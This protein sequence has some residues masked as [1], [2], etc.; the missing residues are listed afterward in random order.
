VYFA[1]FEPMRI[2][3]LLGTAAFMVVGTLVGA[4]VLSLALRTRKLPELYVGGSLFLFAAVGQPLVV[5]SRPLGAAFGYGV[6]AAAVTLAVTA[7][8]AS[9]AGMV[10]FTRTVFRADSSAARWGVWGLASLA[11]LSGLAVVC[12][13][14]E[15]PGELNRSMRLGIAGI[16]IAFCL[17]KA[18]TAWESLRYHRLLRR[19]LALGLSDRVVVNRFLLWGSG[20]GTAC[21]SALAMIA[22]VAAGLDIAVH[23]VPLLTTAASGTLI[24]IC[25]YLT[26]LPPVGYLRWITGDAAGPLGA[27]GQAR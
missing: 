18:W 25:W 8:V 19:R 11:S 27:T 3:A 16:S 15:L 21:L 26:F 2:V 5:A 20:C 6:R 24:A 7:I 14:P 4:R 12:S 13:I 23:P 10:V 9:I 17:G 1:A 22:C